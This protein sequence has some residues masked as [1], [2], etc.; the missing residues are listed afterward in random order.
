MNKILLLSLGIAVFGYAQDHT[1]IGLGVATMQQPY[2]GTKGKVLVIPYLDAKYGGFYMRGIEG[3]YEQT[4]AG[5]L[6]MGAFVKGRLDGYKSSDSDDLSGMQ[7]RK[8][9]IE[10]GVRA[11]IGGYKTGKV[12]AFALN[13]IS[14]THNGYELGLEYSKMFIQEKS[15]IIPYLSLKKESNK[16]TD[17]Y[18]GV[19]SSEATVNRAKYSPK[20]ALNTEIGVRYFYAMSSNIDLVGI[21][22]YTKLDEEIHKSPIVKDKERLKAFVACGYKF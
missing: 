2:K 9:A 8:Y 11:S 17:Y 20:G 10:G 14:G 6:T 12:S 4:L 21:A 3:G 16:L 5:E 15:T 7:E 19:R 18:Y 22:S 1:K 13:D